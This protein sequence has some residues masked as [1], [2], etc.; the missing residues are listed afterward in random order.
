LL[1]YDG[2]GFHGFQRQPD[3]RTVEGELVSALTAAGL[4]GGLG[5]ASRTDTGVHAIGQVVCFNVAAEATLGTLHRDLQSRLPPDIEIR[6]LAWAPPKFHPRWTATGKR[7]VYT[8]HIRGDDPRAWNIPEVVELEALEA[9]LGAL[10]QAPNLT[11][12]TGAGAP[13]RVMPPLTRLV[14]EPTGARWRLV[15]E[16]PAFAK[17]AIRHM[18]GCA[19]AE[20]QGAVPA[21]TTATTAITSAHYRGL[22]APAQG[23]VLEQVYYPPTLDPFAVAELSGSQ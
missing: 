14:A 9:A 5:F 2:A 16:G 8:L 1:A 12:F 18:V 3:Q 4:T 11:G 17:Y 22:R 23:L 19:L 7:Y 20:A 15:V 6:T 21:G 13:L 10:R